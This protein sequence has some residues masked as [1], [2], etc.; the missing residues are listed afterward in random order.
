MIE[1]SGLTGIVFALTQVIKGLGLNSR[2]VP[3]LAIIVGILV[4]ILFS[5]ISNTAIIE[6]LFASLSAMG[7][8]SG[9]Q[10]VAGRALVNR[11]SKK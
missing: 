3:V 1:L 2:Y 8:Y 9:G 7:L 4:S 6:G 5:G 10:A 11:L